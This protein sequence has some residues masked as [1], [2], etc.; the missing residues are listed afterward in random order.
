MMN[1]SKVTGRDAA[2]RRPWRVT[3]PIDFSQAKSAVGV[4]RT[5]QRAVPTTES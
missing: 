4:C 1:C 2:L 5:A 3:G